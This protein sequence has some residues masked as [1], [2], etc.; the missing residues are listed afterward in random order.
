MS[1]RPRCADYT[2]GWICALPLELAAGKTMLDTIHD[3]PV[4][5]SEDSNTYIFGTIGEHNVVMACLANYGLVDSATVAS[6]MAR[7][8]P[9]LQ[10]RFMVGIGGGVSGVLGGGLDIRLGDVVVGKK[11][12]QWD[13]GKT[14][15]GGQF[16]R[17]MKSCTPPQHLDTAIQTLRGHHETTP[18]KIPLILDQSSLAADYAH[19]GPDKDFLFSGSY[20][21][22]DGRLSCD[23]CDH[24]RLILRQPRPTRDP[25]LHYGGIASANQV[26]KDAKT[27][28]RLASEL[29]V[30]CFE[31]DAAGLMNHFPCLVV[32]GISDYSDPHKMKEWQRYAAATASAYV[33]ELVCMIP[34]RLDGAQLGSTFENF[35]NGD[36]RC[37][38]DLRVTDP[39]DDKAR[40]Q[41]TKGGLLRDAYV[42][43]LSNRHFQ[44][45]RS[46][47]NWH[48]S[49]SIWRDDSQIRLL[50]IKG[51]PGKG[52]TMLVCGIIDE[53]SKSESV[54]SFFFCQAADARLNHA[55]SVLRGLI[56]QLVTQ[57]PRLMKYIMPRYRIDGSALFC[58]ANSWEALSNILAS[59]IGDR[60]RPELVL[61]IDA[62]DECVIGLHKL[63]EFIAVSSRIPR[64]KWIVTS[65]N[66]PNV[67][68]S[69]AL[70]T[71]QIRL[72]LELNKNAIAQAVR[73]YIRHQVEE[74]SVV[75]KYD[76]DLKH[77]VETYM[78]TNAQDTFLWV[79]L[80]CANLK[81]YGGVTRNSTIQRLN[82]FPPDLGALYERMLLQIDD[83]SD[84]GP[85]CRRILATASIT[86]R[87]LSVE[88]AHALVESLDNIHDGPDDIEKVIPYCGSFLT[89]RMGFI[90]FVHQS[91]KDFLLK[92][93]PATLFPEGLA[94]EHYTLSLRSIQ[95]MMS[96]LRRN[97]YGLAGDDPESKQV[98]PP[99]P[100]PLA[101]IRYS[102]VYCINHF[103]A[104]VQ[105]ETCDQLENTII[106]FIE[107]KFL[108]W[109]EALSLFESVPA[110]IRSLLEL[111][112]HIQS[113]SRAGVLINDAIRFLRYHKVGIEANPLQVYSSALIFSPKNSE[114]RRLF[115][116]E[117]P[118]WIKQK[119]NVATDWPEY[120][121]TL[122]GDGSHIISMTFAS[123]GRWL[124]SVSKKGK[125]SIHESITGECLSSFNSNSQLTLAAITP[126]GGILVLVSEDS[127]IQIWDVGERRCVNVFEA[128]REEDTGPWQPYVSSIAIAPS[129]QHLAGVFGLHP[130]SSILIYELSTGVHMHSLRGHT[131][132]IHCI[133]YTPD[134]RILSGSSDHSCKVWDTSNGVC[135]RTLAGHGRSV[136]AVSSGPD[137]RRFSSLSLDEAVKIWDIEQGTCM[138]TFEC[139]SYDATPMAFPTDGRRLAVGTGWI[140]IW[141]TKTGAH[142][143]SRLIG[144]QPFKIAFALDGRQLAAGFRDGNI[145]IWN[146]STWEELEVQDEYANNANNSIAFAPGGRWW[147]SIRKHST[148]IP[149]WDTATNM[150]LR[151]T[152]SG[153]HRSP[154]IGRFPGMQYLLLVYGVWQ[155]AKFKKSE[156]P[157]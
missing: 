122:D 26:M 133:T 7:S 100:D 23:Q 8:F 87:P 128:G 127:S 143:Q 67:E 139:H 154:A 81:R 156:F 63:L 12:V 109:V 150:P 92:D 60:G 1:K 80:V 155:Q 24:T 106:S 31:M 46:H 95:L 101:A 48:A 130:R 157:W 40:I 82:S 105:T 21:H 138:W 6:H 88:E 69:F 65:R 57:L 93:F 61:V 115:E 35:I 71:N 9:S 135:L 28:D 112:R 39:R 25:V 83:D 59:M 142:F 107:S 124:A 16:R 134:S 99:Q 104:S 47:T 54:L 10:L 19:P 32:R 78:A 121:Q 98:A 4:T 76:H 137:G 110:T 66:S 103:N 20:N 13:L 145:H 3:G 91:A 94:K 153:Q 43:I 51:D 74:L 73:Y 22:E 5:V 152:A 52:K 89:S 41:Q 30:V 37:L 36:K 64:T 79:A 17:T 151:Q 126:D 111:S 147:A 33:K 55:T 44:Q 140:S 58:G 68:E 50:W 113:T 120:V 15:S 70:A 75:K 149:I 97:I 119:P 14:V 84:D 129:G 146:P 34:P 38:A 144:A 116:N 11:V 136:R 72:C 108:Y 141:D 102:I 77:I 45:W 42:W 125:V 18:S 132:S 29:E 86:E 118:V 27:R 53:L 90:Y 123:D 2:V 85:L 148:P 114:I 117:S 96:T 49:R 131:D 62:L 56:Y